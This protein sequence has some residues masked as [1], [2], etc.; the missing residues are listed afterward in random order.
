MYWSVKTFRCIVFVFICVLQGGHEQCGGELSLADAEPRTCGDVSTVWPFQICRTCVFFILLFPCLLP[1]AVW[2]AFCLFCTVKSLE[3]TAVDFYWRN[4]LLGTTL[5]LFSDLC[6]VYV[7]SPKYYYCNQRKS[8][9][10]Q[11]SLWSLT[12]IN[13]ISLAFY[14][15]LLITRWSLI[16]TKAAQILDSG[17]LLMMPTHSTIVE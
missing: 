6:S 16:Y 2:F 4:D 8:A 13:H 9:Q 11:L 1:P 12:H 5:A 15:N 14:C 7:C 10:S 17:H 3:R